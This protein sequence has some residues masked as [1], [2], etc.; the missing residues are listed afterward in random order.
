MVWRQ[1]VADFTS[2]RVH[3]IYVMHKF[4]SSSN[5]KAADD[6]EGDLANYQNPF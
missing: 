5:E 2:I 3:P 1:S 4:Y 6:A